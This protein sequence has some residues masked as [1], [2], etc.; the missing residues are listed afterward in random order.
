RGT[1]F[2]CQN[3]AGPAVVSAG[4][5]V[6]DFAGTGR[7]SIAVPP[8]VGST[9]WTV[10]L[11]SGTGFNCSTWTGVSTGT[12]P[13]SYL[14]G[15]FTGEG[16]DSIVALDRYN[17]YGGSRLCKSVGNG[18][19]NNTCVPYNTADFIEATFTD[20]ET[21][22]TIFRASGDV[23]GDGRIDFV[24]SRRNSTDPIYQG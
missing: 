8:A 23:T 16:R 9:N 18:F 19:A 1:T 5:V 24:I 7:S 12:G 21:G 14:V 13:N 2:S 22:P 10:C 6:G 4:V 3:W 17:R 15:D 20:S 11:S